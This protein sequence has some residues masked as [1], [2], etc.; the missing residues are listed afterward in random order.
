G[1]PMQIIRPSVPAPFCFTD[2]SS[3]QASEDA[4]RTILN[5]DL[6]HPFDLG[7]AP[8]LRVH[9]VQTGVDRYLLGIAMHHIVSDGWSIGIVMRELGEAYAGGAV[10]AEDL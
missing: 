7:V 8:L 2:V 10:S 3:E 4:G 1:T 6:L 5:R 9:L